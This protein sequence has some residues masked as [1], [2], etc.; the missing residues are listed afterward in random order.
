MGRPSVAEL[1]ELEIGYRVPAPIL[2]LANR[3]LS[4][5]A[6]DVR[7]ARS[8]RVDGAAPAVVRA[9]PGGL[10]DAVR[11]QLTAQEWPTIAVITPDA[12]ASRLGE[13]LEAAGVAF[14]DWTA[15]NLGE[16][17]TLLKASV[18][19]GLEFDAVIL[20]EPF[21]IFEQGR[22]GPRLLYV[23]MTR[24]VQQL[25]VVHSEGLPAL[26]DAA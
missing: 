6:P 14:S 24:P 18:A 17:I 2:E 25:V 11:E 3:L 22:S 16:G 13:D 15:E 4:V 26:L 5:A 9:P 19:K 21:V 10:A 7:P 1:R 8:A 12:L 23:A 20:V